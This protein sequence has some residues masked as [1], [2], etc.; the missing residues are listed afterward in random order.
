[1][2][3]FCTRLIDSMPP[4][5]AIFTP[6]S[7]TER[8]ATAIACKPEA[9]CRS[10]VVPATVT[11]NPARIAP[12]RATFIAV[13]PCCMAHPMTTSSTSPGSTLARLTASP[14]TCPAIVGPS[15]LFSAPRKAF[16]IGV[17]A[18]ETITA[19]VMLSSSLQVMRRSPRDPHGCL[20]PKYGRRSKQSSACDAKHPPD[21][22]P[23]QG[24]I[25]CSDAR[26]HQA[27]AAKLTP[28]G[29]LLESGTKKSGD[30]GWLG[31]TR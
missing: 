15:V 3:S 2:C 9:H 28:G 29:G 20:S 10:I 11:G 22:L 27:L 7:T 13:V 19:S 14:M 4:G 5:T 30:S 25:L 21:D 6:S 17:R 16:P 26:Q 24:E 8:A 23:L 31:S 1:M 12:L 18:V